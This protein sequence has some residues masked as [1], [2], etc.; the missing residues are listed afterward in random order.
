MSR[1]IRRPELTEIQTFVTAVDQG[2][3][4]GAARRLR[5]S[6]AAATK[7]LNNL[8]ALSHGKLLERTSHGVQ[9]T[10]LGHRLL[11]AARRLIRDAETL[12]TEVADPCF[13]PLEGIQQALRAGGPASSPGELLTDLEGLFAWAFR[14][15]SDPIVIADS[16]GIVIDVNQTF[17]RLIGKEREQLAGGPV[18]GLALA[19]GSVRRPDH[20]LYALP[21]RRTGATVTVLADTAD[22]QDQALTYSLHRTELARLPLVLIRVVSVGQPQRSPRARDRTEPPRTR[23][24]RLEQA[25]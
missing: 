16:E 23:R 22:G 19:P 12:L 10:A 7:R 24:R 20:P 25:A 3:I 2:S 17:C 11:P 18:P 4:S 15:A 9:V 8:D 5:I 6:P 21:Q 1:P 13:R 14:V